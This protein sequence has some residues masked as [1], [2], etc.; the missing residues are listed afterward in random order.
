[1]VKR[2]YKKSPL[3]SILVETVKSMSLYPAHKAYVLENIILKDPS[4][5]P[6]ELSIRLSIPL[7]E[8]LVILDELRIY[9]DDL[10]EEIKGFVESKIKKRYQ[11]VCLG[12]TFDI[13]H[14]GHL[15][16][17]LTAIKNG[18]TIIVGV[19][20]DEFIK[21]LNKE[22]PVKP[23]DERL[24]NIKNVLKDLGWDK[25]IV[26]VKLDD[27]YGPSIIDDS[28]EAIVVSPYTLHRV[29]EINT[30]R[31]KRSLRMLDTI[32]CP[33]VLAE[34]GKPISTTRIR[35]GE[36]TPDGRVLKH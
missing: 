2:D 31:S 15:A 8:A 5:T 16:L 18:Q 35:R 27:P 17:F 33:I 21:Q 22:H 25:G 1:M 9:Y 7:G 3:W 19:T 24:A 11:K 14:Y 32:I 6:E 4:I 28:I 23:F 34:D 36:I 20:S 29:L 10:E 26:F 12:G 13:I 30:I